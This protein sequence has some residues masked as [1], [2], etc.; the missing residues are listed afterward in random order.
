MAFL[1]LI[2]ALALIF[3]VLW[4]AFETVILPRR[5]RRR[6]RITSAVYQ[7]TWTPWSAVARH[8]KASNR[9]ES[10]LS[11]YGPLALIFL[12]V[13]WALGLIVGFAL[14][15]LGCGSSLAAADGQHGFFTDLYMS[16]TT[17]FTLGLGDVVPRSD[18]ARF[19]T[20]IEAGIGFAFLAVVIGYLPILYQAFSRREVEVSLLDA[21]AGSPSS[22]VELLRR[23]AGV[24][25][26]DDLCQLLRGWEH[27]SAELLES[28][29]SYP[30][31]GYFRSQHEHQSWVAALTTILDACA[32]I[33]AGV[34]Q[35]PRHQAKLTFA[36]ARHAAVDL[37]QVFSAHPVQTKEDRL[38]AA[39]LGHLR[40]LLATA[41]VMPAPA[42]AADTKLRHLRGM[43]EPY[44]VALAEQLL[45][46]LP[47]WL[48]ADGAKDD[49]QTS[50]DEL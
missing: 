29:L 30:S 48:P 16:G 36:M 41:G 18:L 37:S 23:H 2:P 31:L 46:P 47:P 24:E 42:E 27:W 26:A 34:E 15:E 43:Y 7:L 50:P 13:V 12:L 45:T 10:L 11:L 25:G 9:R 33:L 39:D 17:F 20:V 6:L 4:D 8:M 19:L 32:L 38:P 3:G 40:E 28:H 1:V 22:A 44:A 21:R 35:G 14:L 49:W 5:V